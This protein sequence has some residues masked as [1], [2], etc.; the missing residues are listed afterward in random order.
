MNKVICIPTCN[1]PDLLEITIGSIQKDPTNPGLP[2]L[3]SSDSSPEYR[4]KEVECLKALCNRRPSKI[5]YIDT[6]RSEPYKRQLEKLSGLSR[7]VI[8]MAMN[9]GSAGANRNRL[10]LLTCT[11]GADG[12]IFSDDD[13]KVEEGF[14]EYHNMALGN[15]VSQF[16]SKLKNYKKIQTSLNEELNQTGLDKIIEVFSAGWGFYWQFPKGKRKKYSRKSEYLFE[17][18][19]SDAANLSLTSLVYSTI[20]FP[21]LHIDEDYVLGYH[22]KIMLESIN[23]IILKGSY[24]ISI[25]RRPESTETY[26]E[27]EILET[28]FIDQGDLINI[29]EDVAKNLPTSLGKNFGRE[30]IK[31]I[32]KRIQNFVQSSELQ[33]RNLY[34]TGILYQNWTELTD[35]AKKID[36]SILE[37]FLVTKYSL[38]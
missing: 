18:T 3:V 23:G 17:S 22:A 31:T 27:E 32:G 7:E 10:L 12:I 37:E 13:M 30:L 8:D 4:T 29:S 6:E 19:E 9:G 11:Y 35:A 21:T 34:R 16:L 14:I 20:P 25:N 28:D 24:S 1:R 5:Y 33:E 15:T 2:I 38:N 36:P 26:F